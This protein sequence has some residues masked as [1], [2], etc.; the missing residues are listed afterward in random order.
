MKDSIDRIKETYKAVRAEVKKIMLALKAAEAKKPDGSWL[1]KDITAYL[2][3]KGILYGSKDSKQVL[4]DKL[5][6]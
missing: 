5:E 4:L 6:S 1:R 2:D 3:Q